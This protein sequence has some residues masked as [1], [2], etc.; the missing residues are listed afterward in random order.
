MPKQFPA[1]L[2]G[3]FYKLV[4]RGRNPS[5]NQPRFKRFLK[6]RPRVSNLPLTDA[7]KDKEVDRE[8]LRIKKDGIHDIPD[9]IA[10]LVDYKRWWEKETAAAKAKAGRARAAKAHAKQQ[11][12]KHE[13]ADAAQSSKPGSQKNPKEFLDAI[14]AH[15]AAKTSRRSPALLKIVA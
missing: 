12:E 6:E 3:D 4:V 5:D 14:Y 11:A 13:T 15:S 2:E 7:E 10:F 1:T 9:W 8:F